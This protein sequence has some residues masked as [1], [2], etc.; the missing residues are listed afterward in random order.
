M[1]GAITAVLEVDCHR[2]VAAPI[3]VRRCERCQAF[4]GPGARERTGLLPP[5][6]G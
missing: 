1:T 3:M 2:I 6:N 5:S 4:L